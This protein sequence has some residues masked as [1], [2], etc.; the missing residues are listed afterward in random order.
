MSFAPSAG[1]RPAAHAIRPRTWSAK[2]IRPRVWVRQPRVAQLCR[3]VEVG[4]PIGK[5]GTRARARIAGSSRARCAC[6]TACGAT[7]VISPVRVWATP[8]GN[9]ATRS[10]FQTR[11]AGIDAKNDSK[12]ARMTTVAPACGATAVPTDR[13]RT[14]PCAA[15]CRVTA[16]GRAAAAA[17]GSLSAS[18][19]AQRPGASRA[20]GAAPST[21][22]TATVQRSDD[23]ANGH[24]RNKGPADGRAARGEWLGHAGGDEYG[25]GSADLGNPDQHSGRLAGS[26]KGCE[27][28]LRTR[29]S[30][31]S[32][33][34]DRPEFR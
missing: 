6:R 5:W 30:G 19:L 11:P 18:V 20:A 7:V 26:F 22:S 14:P 4:A 29:S 1:S 23:P 17:A 34:R 15:S 33:A 31:R 9:P 16:A 2:S 8:S 32:A 24:R 3:T 10:R 12:S 25:D 13:P 21:G 27:P 28:G